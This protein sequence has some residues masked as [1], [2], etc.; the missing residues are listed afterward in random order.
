MAEG[1]EYVFQT[2]DQSVYH[3][4][5]DRVALEDAHEQDEVLR[6]VKKWVKGDPPNTKE[7][8]KGLPQDVPSQRSRK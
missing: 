6:V 5:L 7:E 2:F 3:S 1:E 4:K 8:I